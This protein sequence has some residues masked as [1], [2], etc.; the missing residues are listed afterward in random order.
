MKK[1]LFII[2][3]LSIGLFAEKMPLINENTID[4]VYQVPLKKFKR[5]VCE[6]KL[7]NGQIVQFASVKSMM[8][9]Y[10][11]Q[12]HFLKVKLISA[13]IKH[14]FVQDFLTG[15]IVRAKKAVYIFGSNLVQP[16]GA[17]VI[18]CKNMNSA[19][20]F[21]SKYGGVKILKFKDL[22]LKFIRFLDIK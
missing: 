3:L 6:A 22:S 19:K 17:D 9:V 4:M 7:E 21:E 16:K 1:Y 5:F 14:M 2:V 15:N 8:L 11:H 18:P 10:Y 13:K 20:L 12:K